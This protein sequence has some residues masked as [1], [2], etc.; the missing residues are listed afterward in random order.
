MAKRRTLREDEVVGLIPAG[1][2][3][4]RIAP[5]PV[6][7]EIYPIGFRQSEGGHGTR[8]KVVCHYLLEKMRQA[9]IT[10]AYIVLREG[11]WD[12]PAYLRD[13]VLVNMH[14]AYMMLGLPF[15]TPYT[16]D[17]AYPFIQ[18][19]TVAFGFPDIVFQA[20]DAFG[21]LLIRKS[22]SKA[23]VILGLFPAEEPQRLDMV[24]LDNNGAVREILTKPAHTHLSHSW[25][26][27]VWTPV[28]SRFL[29]EYV[30]AHKET[31]AMKAEVSVGQVIQMGI[32]SGIKVEGIAV[33]DRPYLDIG[34]AED[35]ALAV[36]EYVV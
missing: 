29:H 7:K 11:K 30:A 36:R 6:S 35:L 9:G 22:H 14:L 24:D 10:R 23:S 28:F 32:E 34:T 4:T 13:G 25:C 20:D 12:I 1:G 21:Q 26:I 2:L 15:G 18:H 17:Q 5:L 8:P 19:S 31:A 33:S 27:A 16:L 3:A